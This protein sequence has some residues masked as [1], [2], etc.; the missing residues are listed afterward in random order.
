MK[1]FEV[2][3]VG[4][5]ISGIALAI[6]LSKRNV[7]CAVYEQAHAFGELGVGL[8]VTPNAARAMNICDAKVYEAFNKV[9]GA[10]YKWEI[11]DGTDEKTDDF[12]HFTVG[13]GE[14]GVRGCHRAHFLNGLVDLLPP[15]IIRFNKQL[16]RI[17]E[18]AGP[19]GKVRLIFGDGTTAEADAV[20]GSDGIK[21]HT[22]A[23]L[24][25]AN[26]PSAKCT[27]T[28][29]FSYRGLVPMQQAVE[30]LGPN[31]D[32]ASGIWVGND[33]H[34]VTYPVAQGTMLNVV[35][36]CTD[37][38]DWPSETQLT[39]P[40]RLEDLAE[41]T[42]GLSPRI[43]KLIGLI[44]NVDR[45]G[46]FDLGYR[47]LP[48]F[49]KGR[50]CLIGDAAHASTPYQGSGAGICL[51]DAAVLASLLAD[52]RVQDGAG[53]EAA[54]S[55]FDAV[56]RERGHFLVDSSR[57]TGELLQLQSEH[58]KDFAKLEEELHQLIK[59]MW[60][61]DIDKNVTD[62]LENLGKRLSSK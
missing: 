43:R 52:G 60:Y 44:K 58:G 56:R 18:P 35:A 39:L 51:E 59:D 14:S 24:V 31:G 16:D 40:C 25:G 28:H 50:I 22:R 11:L 5:G 7:P 36:H 53:L 32:K 1:N 19:S 17:E 46:Q 54:F 10:P 34:V 8:G 23:L 20:V 15:G 21:S 45:W 13:N 9:S 38:G 27:Y 33:I 61:F 55:A 62:A 3:I 29:K 2:A 42:K 12:V 48:T 47:P 30:V 49:A 6:A 57:R 26:H 41:D 4:G 37:H